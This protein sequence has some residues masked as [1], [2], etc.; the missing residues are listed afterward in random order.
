M[1]N[2]FTPIIGALLLSASS[3]FAATEAPEIPQALVA[4]DGTK[5]TTTE[6][7]ETVRRPE[8]LELFRENIYGRNAVERPESL[9]F[10]SGEKELPAFD[11]KAV[12]KRVVISYKG[13]GGERSINA[14]LYL[15]AKAK[16]KACFILIVNRSRKIIDDAESAPAEFWPVADLISRGYAT[17]AFHY[18]DV[19]PDSAKDDFKSGVFKLYDPEKRPRAGDA[20]GAIAAW[21]WGA[22]RVVDF[23]ETEPRLKGVPIAVAGH[24]RGGKAALWCGAQ[25]ARVA[26]S[27]SNDS[28]TAGAALS[29]VSR[30]ETV[31]KINTVF[32]HWFALN[33]HAFNDRQNELPVDQHELVALIAPR[34]VYIASASDDAN[35]DPAAEFQSGIE[36]APVFA[37]YKKTGIVP[38][39]FPAVGEVR[40]DGAIGYHLRAGVHDLKRYDWE[41]YMNFADKHFGVTE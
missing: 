19:A 36:A 12:R 22:S 7:W 27:I 37:L 1:K 26:L 5:V 38:A 6:A 3:A 30:G 14:T 18:S 41:R 23:L 20:W 32:P 35:A 21:S 10:T 2:R 16:P 34:L 8:L 17:I 29:R 4:K 15:P 39:T 13:P 9:M 25:D 31:K 33:Y 24:S 40:H 11:G 28:G